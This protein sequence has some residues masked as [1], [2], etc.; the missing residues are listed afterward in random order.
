M[1]DWMNDEL[2]QRYLSGEETDHLF[3][4]DDD[5]GLDEL[6]ETCPNCGNVLTD[7]EIEDCYCNK[8]DYQL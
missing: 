7:E 8:C 1:K 2:T 5:T 4:L 6:V 3:P